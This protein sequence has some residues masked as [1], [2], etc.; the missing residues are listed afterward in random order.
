VKGRTFKQDIVI[1]E[2]Q[3]IFKKYNAKSPAVLLS[4]PINPINPITPTID[5]YIYGV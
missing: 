4:Q 1:D 5:P 3:N 2:T